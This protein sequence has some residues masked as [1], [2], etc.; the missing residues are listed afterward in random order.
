M[1]KEKFTKQERIERLQLAK[2]RKQKIEEQRIKNVNNKA[3][4]F[5]GPA[6]KA[7]KLIAILVA[8]LSITQLVDGLLTPVFE[9]NETFG[10]QAETID[11]VTP[12][13]WAFPATFQQVFLN[14]AKTSVLLMHNVHYLVLEE[15][16]TLQVG[17]SPIFNAPT[18][19]I[20]GND[21]VNFQQDIE[22]DI[23]TMYV[24]PIMTLFFALIAIFLNPA[25]NMQTV[26]FSYANLVLMPLAFIII[27]IL[28]FSQMGQI[29]ASIDIYSLD[30]SGTQLIFKES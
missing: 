29:N 20:T 14:E 10:A 3:K 19:F 24:I 16:G 26:N 9:T 30:V 1:P 12:D 27:L 22:R 6:G 25:S 17:R 21:R 5:L 28:T 4:L 15:G 2:E 13:G 11:L 8:L 7:I 23:Y 18:S